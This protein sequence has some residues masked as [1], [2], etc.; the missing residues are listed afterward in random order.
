MSADSRIQNDNNSQNP[1]LL[2]IRIFPTQEAENSH[3]TTKKHDSPPTCQT[4]RE[5]Q[6]SW[7]VITTC[8]SC[9]QC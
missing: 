3:P 5:S 8:W 4:C 9:S 2:D 6:C 7:S 1:F